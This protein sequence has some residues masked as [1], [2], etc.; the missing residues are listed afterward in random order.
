MKSWEARL[1]AAEADLAER[2]RLARVADM[3]PDEQ[4]AFAEEHDK[5]ARDRDALADAYDDLAGLRDVAGLTRDVRASQRDQAAREFADDRDAAALDRFVAGSDRDLAAGDRGDAVDDRAR[6]VGARG[7]AAA[8]RK[9]AAADRDAASTGSAGLEKE[10]VQL[11]EA[12]ATRLVI[13]QAEG[14][15]MARHRLDEGAAFKLLIKLSQESGFKVREVAA[16]VV[17]DASA[18]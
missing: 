7:R 18:S 1:S 5:L 9:R 11:R 10:L 8:D 13:G 6:A 2:E 15:L 4:R 17:R 3:T 16:R 14:L 12:L